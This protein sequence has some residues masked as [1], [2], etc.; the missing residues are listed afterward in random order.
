MGLK[1]QCEA[2]GDEDKEGKRMFFGRHVPSLL[3]FKP[4]FWRERGKEKRWVT[5]T[6]QIPQMQG[7]DRTV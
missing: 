4:P 1:T 5:L 3:F 2:E 6:E 7:F